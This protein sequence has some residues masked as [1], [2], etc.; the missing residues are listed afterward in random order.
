MHAMAFGQNEGIDSST[1]IAD[2]AMN[3]FRAIDRQTLGAE[4]VPP[5]DHAATD[6]HIGFV[7]TPCRAGL[8]AMLAPGR[9]DH[10]PK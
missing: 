9:R 4:R 8:G 5:I 3:N 1:I 7:Q 6:L 10:R 2:V